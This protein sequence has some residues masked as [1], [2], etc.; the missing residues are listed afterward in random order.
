MW[1]F[2]F[3]SSTEFLHNFQVLMNFLLSSKWQI[4]PFVN[5]IREFLV[6]IIKVCLYFEL[7]TQSRKIDCLR[8]CFTSNTCWDLITPLQ[9]LHA[10]RCLSPNARLWIK[11]IKWSH[12]SQKIQNKARSQVT[13]KNSSPSLDFQNGRFCKQN[14]CIWI[15]TSPQRS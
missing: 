6:F 2:K 1:K 9:P 14:S 15:T 5:A 13:N 11:L 7:L 8:N 3:L 10:S 4:E 12:Q